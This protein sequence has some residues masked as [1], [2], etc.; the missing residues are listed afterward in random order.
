MY[1][2]HHLCVCYSLE[3]ALQ[4][5]CMPR[6]VITGRYISE[7][8]F[9]TF[10]CMWLK[11]RSPSNNKTKQEVKV[12]TSNFKFLH[13]I[14]TC[15]LWQ[16]WGQRVQVYALQTAN[17]INSH[18][19]SNMP[20]QYSPTCFSSLNC[21]SHTMCSGALWCRTGSSL[22]WTGPRLDV[23]VDVK[24]KCVHHP[25]KDRHI[26]TVEGNISVRPANRKQPWQL[27]TNWFRAAQVK[28]KSSLH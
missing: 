19:N 15:S 6:M 2:E 20:M 13:F 24:M 9:T 10:H 5:S 11:P 17:T 4:T 26:R 28:S 22:V 14:G 18:T 1:S 25:T 7:S 3:R 23:W 27:E 21:A 12:S 8:T 16:Y